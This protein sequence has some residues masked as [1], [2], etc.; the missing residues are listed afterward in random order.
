MCDQKKD[1]G[2]PI[3]PKTGRPIKP[4]IKK[5]WVKWLFP[6]TGLAAL[7]WFLIRVIP[8]PS[9]A[10]YPCQ[11]V[12]FPLA[13]SFI[14]YIL[15]IGVT[16]LVLRKARQRLYQSR[17]VLAG[18][19]LAAAL[20]SAWLTISINAR[21][22]DA[23][24]VPIDP[25]N[26]PMGTAKGIFPG[27]V[28]WVHDANATYWDPSWNSRTDIHYWDDNHTNTNV[29][30]EMFSNTLCRL[31]GE[32]TDAGAWDKLFK[33]FNQTHG[34]GNVGYTQGEKIA[35]KPN[36][37]EHRQ[38]NDVDNYADISP[39]MVAALLKQLVWE[40]GIDQ[41]CITVCD[42]ARYISNKVF[43]RCHNLFPDITY[44][45]TNYYIMDVNDLGT[46]PN[47]PP[48][49]PTDIDVIF[50]SSL[51]YRNGNTPIP[52]D[53]IPVPFYEA[54]YIIS[55]AIMKGHPLAGVTMS[56]KN[57]YGCF[58]TKPGQWA[59]NDAHHKMHPDVVPQYG[60]YRPMVD[61]MG[62]EHLGGKTM[63]FIL[64]G[65]Y[66][67]Q[68][69]AK[70]G[71]EPKKWLNTPFNNDYPSSILMSQDSVAI[72]SVG[73]DFLRTEFSGNMGGTGI[74]GA[75][76]DYLHEAA[77]ADD[78]CSG[79]F[80]DPMHPLGDPGKT[81]IGSIGTHEHWNSST[82]KQYTRNLGTGPGIELISAPTTNC[83]G[84]LNGDIDGD[85]WVDYSDLYQMTEHWLGGG[86]DPN[87]DLDG[88]G[89]VDFND[90][91]ILANNWRKCNIMPQVFQAGFEDGSLDDW[92]ATDANAWRI[93]D[94]N[95]GRPGKAL[96]LFK[97]SVY[98][99]PYKSPKNIILIPDVNAGSFVLELQMLSTTPYYPKRDLCL[100][101]G[102]QDASHFY[103]AHIADV[104]DD[105][106]HRIH[107][108][109]GADRTPIDE[110]R[111]GGNDWGGGWHTVRVVRDADTGAI[112]VFFDNT[113]VMTATNT[114]FRWGRVGVG[115]F[116]DTGQFDN[117]RLWGR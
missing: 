35:I 72:D 65:L 74:S 111:N 28:A 29:V 83:L 20:F 32:V 113:L 62:H 55:F 71:S 18:V 114:R 79:T 63:L 45:E 109:D 30:E 22:A 80:Y 96:A 97:Q 2:L 9:R 85:Y 115:S 4:Y 106:H 87:S 50:Y 48:V 98:T 82:N 70:A 81:R 103:Y 25:A 44:T 89:A 5:R 68:R 95:S 61:L 107:I 17:Y 78:P 7:I 102:Y 90:F 110:T 24:Y 52:N 31:T 105:V 57:W 15:G 39:Q 84:P 94:A 38:H 88:S 47:R 92:Q 86:G 99:P 42:S 75:I 60:R 16:A 21:R 11:R 34:K 36:F 41:N 54:D 26:S 56:G 116:D 73:L 13:S 104:A 14:A 77:L 76:D 58:C 3:C 64:D 91:A 8:K 40:A 19:C 43:Y 53:K 12:A 46:D 6:I 100:F 1:D 33:H 101:F 49:Q 93:A 10:T 37:V 23:A 59:P 51:N 117:I 66:G 27:R 108:V 67:F 112:K 69:E